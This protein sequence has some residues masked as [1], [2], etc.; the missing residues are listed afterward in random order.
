METQRR[1]GG[2]SSRVLKC[3]GTIP[4]CRSTAN[5]LHVIPIVLLLYVKLYL[6]NTCTSQL[7]ENNYYS[8]QRLRSMCI[9][10]TMV[11]HIQAR[12]KCTLC[13]LMFQW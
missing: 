13:V 10:V 12:H 8:L 7:F 6:P 2:G 4:R 9:D 3:G 5:T 11:R 1:M